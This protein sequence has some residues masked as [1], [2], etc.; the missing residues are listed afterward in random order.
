MAPRRPSC[1]RARSP[2]TA[3]G[4]RLGVERARDEVKVHPMI[5]AALGLAAGELSTKSEE[6]AKH[7]HVADRERFRL[8]LWSIQERS[9]GRIRS[10][11]RLRQADNSYRWFELE[12]ASV[13]SSDRRAVR[14]RVMRDVRRPGVRTSACC[15]TRCTTA[16]RDCRTASCSSIGS[17]SPCSAPRPSRRP[18]GPRHRH[19]QVPVGK[20]RVRAR[21]RRQPAADHRAAAAAPSGPQDTLAR[22]G[23]DQFAILFVAE[24]D[25]RAL[26]SLAERIRRSLRSPI[27]ISGKEVVVTGSL[28]IAVYDGEE[29]S[30]HDL[31]KEAEMAMFRAKRGGADRIEIF[32]PEMRGDRRSRR[33]RERSQEGLEKGR[34]RSSTS[35]SSRSPPRSSPVSRRSCAGSIPR[36]G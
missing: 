13:P 34:S 10:D 21:R 17:A 30:Q 31:L 23:G 28:G 15:T 9:G 19:R 36:P 22:V 20:C 14:V 26:A 18:P 1:R 16:S 3:R 2:S 27:K 35:R 24:Q 5:E 11:F 4:G 12:A 33:A 32:S 25:P 29:E 8:M 7:L 6:F